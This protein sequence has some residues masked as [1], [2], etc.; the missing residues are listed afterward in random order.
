[1][2]PN[3]IV[4]PSIVYGAFHDW[5]GVPFAE[6]PLFYEGDEP[7]ILFA[8]LVFN[9]FLLYPQ[10]PSSF[11]MH[12]LALCTCKLTWAWACVNRPGRVWR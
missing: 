3:A 6:M 10:M 1:M 8:R 5:N 7:Y 4:H 2:N 11:A 9:C 12:L